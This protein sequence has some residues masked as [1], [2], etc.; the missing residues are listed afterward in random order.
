MDWQDPMFPP[1]TTILLISAAKTLRTGT[2]ERLLDMRTR[3]G[4]SVHLALTGDVDKEVETFDL[5][6]YYLG[7]KE[8]WHELIRTVGDEKSGM[9]GTSTASLQLD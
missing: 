1:G 7:G 2:V 5:P 8:K 9:V 4:S 6:V 3:R